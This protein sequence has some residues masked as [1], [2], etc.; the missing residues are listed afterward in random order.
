M[1]NYKLIDRMEWT[2]R[3]LFWLG[4]IIIMVQD[5]KILIGIVLIMAAYDLGEEVNEM[6]R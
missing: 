1:K 2:A 3:V 4:A 5:W 6:K